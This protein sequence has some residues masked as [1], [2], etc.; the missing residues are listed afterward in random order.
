M[1]EGTKSRRELNITP[2]V[3]VCW[4]CDFYTDLHPNDPD[5][6]RTECQNC[7]ELTEVLVC[8][9]V[10]FLDSDKTRVD[11]IKKCMDLLERAQVFAKTYKMIAGDNDEGDYTFR[12]ADKWLSDY[13]KL[14]GGVK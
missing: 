2:Y 6:A 11:E 5:A 4:S 7:D 8:R 9:P 3:G 12:Q 1:T 10:G 13:E 14:K